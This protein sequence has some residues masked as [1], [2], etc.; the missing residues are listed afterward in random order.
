M[1]SRGKI[2]VKHFFHFYVFLKVSVMLCIRIAALVRRNALQFA[3]S[4]KID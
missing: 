2:D 3:N 4:L 1:A